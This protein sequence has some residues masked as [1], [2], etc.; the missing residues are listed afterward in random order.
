MVL[1]ASIFHRIL[2]LVLQSLAFLTLN[3]RQEFLF[4][5]LIRLSNLN[6]IGQ[7]YFIHYFETHL[8]I[9]STIRFLTSGLDLGPRYFGETTRISS[10]KNLYFPI[11]L[12]NNF[13]EFRT[14]TSSTFKL[15]FNS[16]WKKF[17]WTQVRMNLIT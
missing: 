13:P 8:Y 12:W 7:K 6:L 14:H 1:E 10:F 15:H 16:L 5:L 3:K 9:I 4:V 11:S 2:D 17:L